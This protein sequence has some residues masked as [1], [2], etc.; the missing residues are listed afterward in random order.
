MKLKPIYDGCGESDCSDFSHEPNE[1][2]LCPSCN[3]PVQ[4]GH[5]CSDCN[6]KID[7]NF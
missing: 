7:W 5:N 6:Q 2:W 1:I 4:K 3:E